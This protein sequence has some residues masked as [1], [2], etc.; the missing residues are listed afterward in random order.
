MKRLG[1]FAR[2]LVAMAMVVTL[3]ILTGGVMMATLV[4]F[5]HYAAVILSRWGYTL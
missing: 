5:I 1:K 2:E 3:A 4:T